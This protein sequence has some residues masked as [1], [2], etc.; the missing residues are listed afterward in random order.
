[1]SLPLRK[2]LQ[3]PTRFDE[4][5]SWA[6]AQRA[7]SEL[8]QIV[9]PSPEE[10]GQVRDLH[11]GEEL[12]SASHCFHCIHPLARK[13]EALQKMPREIHQR[14][15]DDPVRFLWRYRFLHHARGRCSGG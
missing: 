11:T 1:M 13:V 10:V 8:R 15:Q 9:D 4:A 5:V 6:K 2:E 7:F 14:P 3:D 12:P